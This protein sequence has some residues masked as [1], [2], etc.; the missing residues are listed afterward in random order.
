MEHLRIA[1]D[2]ACLPMHRYALIAPDLIVC[3]TMILQRI[4]LHRMM[5]FGINKVK[6]TREF[7]SKMP[8]LLPLCRVAPAGYTPFAEERAND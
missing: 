2:S 7:P 3:A 6:G 4:D 5:R 1:D 8:R